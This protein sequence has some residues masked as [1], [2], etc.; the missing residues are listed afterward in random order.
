MDARL[1]ATPTAV[2]E[3]GAGVGAVRSESPPLATEATA[4]STVVPL[5]F[6]IAAATASE[7]VHQRTLS[8]TLGQLPGTGLG[9]SV[10]RGVDMTQAERLQAFSRLFEQ[11]LSAARAIESATVV[12]TQMHDLAERLQ[13]LEKTIAQLDVDKRR[14]P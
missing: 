6:Q 12:V 3:A 13:E 1:Q 4:G 14:G 7:Q 5:G 9:S 2:G 11:Q 8:S 10:E